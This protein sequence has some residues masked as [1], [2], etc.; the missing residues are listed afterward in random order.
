MEAVLRGIDQTFDKYDR[1]HSKSQKINSLAYCSQ[2][3]LVAAEEMKEA[4]VGTAREKA[5]AVAGLV[6]AEIAPFFSSNAE[7]LRAQSAA[8]AAVG[9]GGMRCYTYDSG[10]RARRRQ[11]SAWKTWSGG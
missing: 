4:A 9:G 11:L 2:A 1:R 7:K 8:G 6:P 5:S 10:L 3:V